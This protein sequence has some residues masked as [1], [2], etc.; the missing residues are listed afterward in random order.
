M[1]EPITFIARSIPDVHTL[2]PRALMFRQ[3]L[4]S[5]PEG[6]L[7]D[8]LDATPGIAM[9]ND[10]GDGRYA[11]RLDA[12]T[13]PARDVLKTSQPIDISAGGFSWSAVL[14]PGTGSITDTVTELMRPDKSKTARKPSGN[15]NPDVAPE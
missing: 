1:S 15:R 3:G 5:A 10:L 4:E 11:L 14:T 8:V 6:T 2:L 7:E 13:T 12:A 9:R